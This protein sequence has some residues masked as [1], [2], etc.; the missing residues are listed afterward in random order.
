MRRAPQA[1]PPPTRLRWQRLPA[2]P[3]TATPG[4]PELDN[5]QRCA[6]VLQ[7]LLPGHHHGVAFGQALGDF[8][9][10]RRRTP[11]LTSWRSD[12]HRVLGGRQAAGIGAAGTEPPP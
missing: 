12:T 5:A 2:P 11:S 1:R 10:P 9:L 7:A 6:V 8:D 4:W 3:G